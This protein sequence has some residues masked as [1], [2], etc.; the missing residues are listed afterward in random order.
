M[1]ILSV[2]LFVAIFAFIILTVVQLIINGV[3]FFNSDFKDSDVEILHA[4]YFEP[5]Y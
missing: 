5:K 4:D 3:K 2:L 1:K